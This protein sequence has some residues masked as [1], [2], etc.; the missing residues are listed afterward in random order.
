M[1]LTPMR[2][3]WSR[4]TKLATSTTCRPALQQSTVLEMMTQRIK[5]PSIDGR[6]TIGNWNTTHAVGGRDVQM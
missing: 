4:R 6:R 1:R 3:C 5:N 2:P